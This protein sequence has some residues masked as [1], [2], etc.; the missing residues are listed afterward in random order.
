VLTTALAYAPNGVL[1]EAFVRAGDE[2][3]VQFA[4]GVLRAREI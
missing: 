3:L 4:A 1:P 2:V